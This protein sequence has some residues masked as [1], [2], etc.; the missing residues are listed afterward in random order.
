MWIVIYQHKCSI[1]HFSL[2]MLSSIILDDD[3]IR[4]KNLIFSI[5]PKINYKTIEFIMKTVI[6]DITT[7]NLYENYHLPVVPKIGELIN[8]KFTYNENEDFDIMAR[9]IDIHYVIFDYYSSQNK[10]IILIKS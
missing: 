5:S 1:C 4:Y 10:I 6:K 3:L 2:A 9:V 7:N 8:I